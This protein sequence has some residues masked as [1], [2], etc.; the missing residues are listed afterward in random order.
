MNACIFICIQYIYS[1]KHKTCPNDGICIRWRT[2]CVVRVRCWPQEAGRVC[3][4]EGA[5]RIGLLQEVKRLDI[6]AFYQLDLQSI[7]VRNVCTCLCLRITYIH[8][9]VCIRLDASPRLCTTCPCESDCDAASMCAE[10]TC[11]CMLWKYVSTFAAPW[12]A[13]SL[14]K[15]N[16]LN[17]PWEISSFHLVL[18]LL[19]IENTE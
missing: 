17:F 7:P 2:P 5:V 11:P 19:E 1:Q 8:V 6:V 18:C 14:N 16:I 4:G 3:Y 13:R 9:Y 15:L 10:H 12:I